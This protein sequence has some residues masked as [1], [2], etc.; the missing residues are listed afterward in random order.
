M[1]GENPGLR[2]EPLVTPGHPWAEAHSRVGGAAGAGDPAQVSQSWRAVTC[3][4]PPWTTASPL[5][6]RNFLYEQIWAGWR[7][8][9][10]AAEGAGDE[11]DESAG[12][13]PNNL[14]SP[15]SPT[16]RPPPATACPRS[17]FP[18]RSCRSLQDSRVPHLPASA[19]TSRPAI[20]SF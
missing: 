13:S 20:W 12:V 7:G 2:R 14:R 5:L 6:G 9:E 19:H 1:S 10:R 8:E 11:E 4:K 18:L 15:R 17:I 3:W 16:D